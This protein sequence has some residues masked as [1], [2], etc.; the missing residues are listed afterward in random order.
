MP[1]VNMMMIVP[2]TTASTF[3]T[4]LPEAIQ[5]SNPPMSGSFVIYCIWGDNTFSRTRDIVYNEKVSN[6][7]NIL[8]QDCPKLRDSITVANGPRYAFRDD[9]I[10]LQINFWGVKEPL[11]Q[12][13]I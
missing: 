4:K 5:V 2:N 13:Y 11:G 6:I 8:Q 3:S 9:G 7:Q 1:S 12:F 10:D